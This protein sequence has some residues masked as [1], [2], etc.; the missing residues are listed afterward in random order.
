MSSKRVWGRDCGARRDEVWLRRIDVPHTARLEFAGDVRLQD[1]V[2]AGGAAE[3]LPVGGIA[4]RKACLLRER[5]RGH[6]DLSTVL[7]LAGRLIDD[8]QY[9][10]LLQWQVED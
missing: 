7:Y 4:R 9:P 5:L 2:G 6:V 3:Q 1:V 10:R 8:L